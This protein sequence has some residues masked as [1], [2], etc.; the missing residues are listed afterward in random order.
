VKA[1]HKVD[2]TGAHPRPPGG[3]GGPLAQ[4]DEQV[5]RSVTQLGNRVDGQA[6]LR[7]W[8]ESLQAPAWDGPQ[9]WVHGDLLPGNLL[10]L[11]GRLSAVIDFGGL[12]V[13]DPA[14]DLQP[15]WYLFDGASPARYRAE[16]GID[17][18]TWL[19]GRGLGTV[20]GGG[21][22]LLPRHR[23]RHGAPGHPYARPGAGR[24]RTG[25]G[26][27]TAEWASV[28]SCDMVEHWAGDGA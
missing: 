2:V 28:V 22:G 26:C 10:V 16:L 5:R 14:C 8:R 19:R 12:N 18:A 7:S 17:N 6:I 13:G 3:R 11:N 27:A 15:A 24:Q 1:L 21:A 25:L 23:P 9:V 20:R 4:H